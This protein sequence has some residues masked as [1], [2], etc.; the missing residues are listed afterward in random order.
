M[1]ELSAFAKI[2][3]DA[4]RERIERQLTRVLHDGTQERTPPTQACSLPVALDSGRRSLLAK[5]T[6]EISAFRNQP[7]WGLPRR[8]L[9]SFPT[10]RPLA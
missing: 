6:A 5:L 7:P 2:G 9:R 10:A 1:L 3:T 8:I 4:L